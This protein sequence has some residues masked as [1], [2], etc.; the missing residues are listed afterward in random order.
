M[1]SYKVLYY[2]LRFIDDSNEDKKIILKDRGSVVNL[3]PKISRIFNECYVF[4]YIES[5][6]KKQL[7]RDFLEYYDNTG[8]GVKLRF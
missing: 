1:K 6:S 5:D 2:E 7:D 8:Y 3:A 4:R